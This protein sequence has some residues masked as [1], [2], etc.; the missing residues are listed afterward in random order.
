M[1]KISASSAK[2]PSEIHCF[3]PLIRQPPS[4]RVARVERF[5]ASEPVSGSVRAKQPS[6]SSVQRRGSHS[7]FCSSVPQRSI[8]LHTSE[9]CTDT[10]VRA[11]ESPRP[12]SS[13][14]SP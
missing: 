4:V 3:C 1:A 11:D 10:T 13:T 8:E 7:R 12:I 2:L 5:A 9:V 14:I 6:A